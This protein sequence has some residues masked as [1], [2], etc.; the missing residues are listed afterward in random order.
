MKRVLLIVAF[1]V[2]IGANAQLLEQNFQSSTNVSSYVSTSPSNGQFNAI[3]TSGPNTTVS[4]AT[5]GSNNVLRYIRTVS[6]SGSFSRTTDFPS[7]NTL[8]Y[9]F[10]LSVNAT[11]N[12]TNSA[13]F[14]IGSGFG[15]NNSAETNANTYA[16]FGINLVNSPNTFA[17]R[18]IT[19]NVNSPNLTG[20]QT[21]LWVLNNSG[22]SQT[23]AN[24]LGTQSS[25]ANDKADIWAGTTLLFDDVA[26][27]TANQTISDVKFVISSDPATID[28]DNILIDPIPNSPSSS[29]ATNIATT[30][31]AANWSTISG[32]TGYR[33]DVSTLNDFSSFVSGYEN[34]YVP[35][36]SSTSINVT[37]LSQGTTYYYRVRGASQ[38]SSGEFASGNSNVQS[39][40]T[41]AGAPLPVKF[42]TLNAKWANKSVSLKW[43]VATEENLGGYQVESSADGRNYSKI[44]FVG[45]T[46]ASTYSFVDTKPSP[47]TYYRIKSIDVD[48]RFGYS[49][50][51]LVKSGK[52][53]II[54]KAF[55]TPFIKS[56]SI[57]HGTATA[58][59]LITISSEDGRVI[60]SVVPAIGTQQ[61]EV[62]LS[63]AKAGMYLVRYSNSNGEAETLKVL[64]Q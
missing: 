19:S 20:T 47:I 58:G 52:S 36:A 24:P 23:Y 7:T 10:D 39:V 28:I 17:I 33:I 30:S 6:Q 53:I 42:E 31:F 13:V 64:K 48:G 63:S 29:A 25:V 14:Q 51:A 49:T 21:I 55:P 60:K 18:D 41:A 2:T 4:I 27:L 59:S 8:M 1:A 57:Q 9:K 56:L 34:L 35:D 44:G 16:R 37:G 22:N 12:A 32:V 54:L 43:N 62:D 61:T 50:V 15:T 40:T 38:Y 3:G 26:V 5:V 45:A 11:T 46:G